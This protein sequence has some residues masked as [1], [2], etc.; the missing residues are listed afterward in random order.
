M[1][2]VYRISVPCQSKEWGS[3]S[4]F[5]FSAPFTLRPL[6]CLLC[7]VLE[8]GIIMFCWVGSNFVFCTPLTGQ[9]IKGDLWQSTGLPPGRKSRSLEKSWGL[10]TVSEVKPV[11]FQY[12]EKLYSGFC[13]RLFSVLNLQQV[14]LCSGIY[15]PRWSHVLRMPI[16]NAYHCLSSTGFGQRGWGYLLRWAT[17]F[18]LFCFR[19]HS[20]GK[21]RGVSDEI[22]TEILFWKSFSFKALWSS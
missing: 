1:K 16:L 21:W 5:S 13:H 14:C 20:P 8:G 7:Y 15:T 11:I 6:L 9:N 17:W 19:I 22:S 10:L 18:T 3:S 12:P 2:H 4:L